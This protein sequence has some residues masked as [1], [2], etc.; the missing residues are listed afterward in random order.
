VTPERLRAV[1]RDAV[2]DVTGR[3]PEKHELEAT[4]EGASSCPKCKGKVRCV[5]DDAQDSEG[6]THD[7]DV[8]VAL[9]CRDAECKWVSRHWRPW[10]RHRPHEL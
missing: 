4:V 10:S 7:L 6:I 3:I 2:Q 8:L 5:I 1:L 9:Y